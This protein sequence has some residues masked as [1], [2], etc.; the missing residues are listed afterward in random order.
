MNVVRLSA[1][2]TGPPLPPGN[3]PGTHFCCGP[4]SSVGIATDYG[5]VGPG[6]ESRCGRDFPP[7]QTGPGAH[8]TSCT[9][10]T[11][12][13]PGVKSGRGV[14]LTTQPLLAPKSWKSR[15]TPLAPH[16][17]TTGTVTGLQYLLLISVGGRVDPQGQSAAGRIVTMKNSSDTIGNQTR[18]L[19]ACSTVPQPTAPPRALVRCRK[20]FLKPQTT[21]CPIPKLLQ[22]PFRP[23]GVMY[24]TT[25]THTK[26]QA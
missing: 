25:Q 4:G 8:P 24:D 13:F 6:I 9:M 20:L 15:A 10:G 5:L 7:V 26:V 17:A 23:A 14:T 19:P 12:S 3:I 1:L 2:R 21:C 22:N 16:W 18:D 11:G